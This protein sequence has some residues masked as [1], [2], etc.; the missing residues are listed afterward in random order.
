MKS[1]RVK[2]RALIILMFPELS[3]L[4]LSVDE[5]SG[6]FLEILENNCN[7][8]ERSEI[9]FEFHGFK[10]ENWEI[11]HTQAPQIVR[12][13]QKEF[14][15]LMQSRL[16]RLTFPILLEVIYTNLAILKALGYKKTSTFD[17]QIFRGEFPVHMLENIGLAE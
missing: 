8:V 7:E 11:I 1:I 5:L 2:I 4:G 17:W 14:E 9:Y 13:N 15:M 10:I 6:Q 16:I 12:K 3:T